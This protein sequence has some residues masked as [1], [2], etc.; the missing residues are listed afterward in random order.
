MR[1]R[2][3]AGG[4][5][6]TAVALGGF[7]S[8]ASAAVPHTVVPGET[9]WSI[10]AAN[11]FTTRTVAAFNG[12]SEDAY[13]VAGQTLEIP[14]VAEGAAALAAA[15]D[16]AAG[17]ST[18]SGTSGDTSSATVPPAPGMGHVPSPWGALHLAPAAADAWNAMRAEALRIY[19]VDLQPGGP[20]S[21]YRTYDQQAELYDLYLS[22][23]GAPANPP[24]SSSHE[25]GTAVDVPTPQMR[26][27]IDEIG[28]LFG[29]GKVH[30]PGEWWHVDY[31]GG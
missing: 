11:N 8:A 17:G 15:P 4:M 6:A 3:V 18:Q 2:H 22:G 20:M 28:A 9:L 30:A 31:V 19:G 23:Q 13:V 25:V 1:T 16:P 14:T 27:I 21:A 26:Q 24:G 5:V 12:L 29:W 10:A 7:A